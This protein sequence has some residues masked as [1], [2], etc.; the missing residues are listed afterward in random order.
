MCV[1][2]VGDAESWQTVDGQAPD[3]CPPGGGSRGPR[4]AMAGEGAVAHDGAQLASSAF[5]LEHVRTPGGSVPPGGK[6]V[7]GLT[8]A[9]KNWVPTGS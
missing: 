3:S 8:R 2:L 5:L 9:P 1:A 7:Q 4:V 6:I